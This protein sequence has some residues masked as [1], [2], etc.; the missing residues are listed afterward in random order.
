[1]LKNI[2]YRL[3][4]VLLLLFCGAIWAWMLGVFAF[5]PAGGLSVNSAKWLAPGVLSMPATVAVI[6]GLIGLLLV[7]G[8]LP[9]RRVDEKDEK[10][11][12]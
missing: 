9:L 7:F 1:M 5:L 8:V 12:A 4:G 2:G 10:D 6:A 3:L 11:V